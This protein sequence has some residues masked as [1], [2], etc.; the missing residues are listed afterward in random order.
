MEINGFELHLLPN[1]SAQPRNFLYPSTF[2]QKT[3]SSYERSGD[4]I[5]I[6]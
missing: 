6:S 5:N 1:C 2:G 3:L 4:D